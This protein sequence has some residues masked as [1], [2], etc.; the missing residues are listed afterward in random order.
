V[1]QAVEAARKA[2]VKKMKSTPNRAV[3]GQ[4]WSDPQLEAFNK[5]LNF[6]I[7]YFQ[8]RLFLSKNHRIIIVTLMIPIFI[9]YLLL[10]LLLFLAMYVIL[11]LLSSNFLFSN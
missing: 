4:V 1:A 6:Y 3:G 5:G 8:R 11:G 10:L 7:N 9:M 2:Q